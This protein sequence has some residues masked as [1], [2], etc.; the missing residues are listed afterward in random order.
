LSLAPSPGTR[1]C[2]GGPRPFYHCRH[3]Y[4]STL[5][6]RGRSLS[7]HG[8][9]RARTGEVDAPFIEQG[10]G[11]RIARAHCRA[12]YSQA[13]RRSVKCSS[14]ARPDFTYLSL[15]ATARSLCARVLCGTGTGG[16]SSSP[17]PRAASSP[18]TPPAGC[19]DRARP[20]IAAP[21]HR[22]ARAHPESPVPRFDRG[23]L[24][25]SG[26]SATG[27]DSH[28]RLEDRCDGGT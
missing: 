24:R 5:S 9:G 11:K 16:E 2:Q 13:F 19:S 15:A 17:S 10:T 14:D 20:G 21:N 28:G 27:A 22:P 18:G 4:I 1:S 7:S 26:C 6:P 25:R 3:T 12:I 23:P 8:V